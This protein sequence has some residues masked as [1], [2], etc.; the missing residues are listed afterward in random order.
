[1]NRLGLTI[2]LVVLAIL[3]SAALA[4][5]QGPIIANGGF[6]TA[7]FTGWTATIPPGGT[8]TVATSY[9]ANSD[10]PDYPECQF[11][12][13]PTYGPKEGAYFALLKT[14]GADS[15][16]VVEQDVTVTAGDVATGWAFFNC[17]DGYQPYYNDTSQLGILS[18]GNVVATPFQSDCAAVGGGGV[19]PWTQWSYTFPAPGTYTIQ[20]R[21][22][23]MDALGE[24]DDTCD[25]RLGLDS[26][27]V[28]DP[29]GFTQGKGTVGTATY[30]FAVSYNSQP[31]GPPL[32]SAKLTWK[33]GRTSK[34][35][36]STALDWLVV[37]DGGTAAYISGSGKIGGRGSYKFLLWATDGNP[38]LL[39]MRIWDAKSGAVQFDNNV[40]QP[41]VGSIRV[42][43]MP[44][45]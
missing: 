45:Q 33:S 27:V 42:G 29:S 13:G 24:G 40:L 22:A 28:Y 15:Y 3:A 18:N 32:G 11:P 23:N 17:L 36:T 26:V 39:R 14:N 10:P 9:V 2:S 21:V 1:M 19:T 35:F 41:V 43:L 31:A 16:T 37:T 44:L 12:V 34:A 4:A 8:A 6:E 30:E 7:D 5:A 25:S 20:A 38:D